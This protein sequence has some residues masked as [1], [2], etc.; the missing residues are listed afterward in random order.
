[1]VCLVFAQ[2]GRSYGKQACR[3]EN[4][5][6]VSST[7]QVPADVSVVGVDR[8]SFV[9]AWSADG[10]T[11]IAKL[12]PAGRLKSKVDRVER[13]GGLVDASEEGTSTTDTEARRKTESVKTFWPS[14]ERGSI[15]AT[16]LEVVSVGGGRVAL[17]MIGRPMHGAPGGA[18]GAIWPSGEGVAPAATRLGPAGEY[19]TRISAAAKGNKL[20]VAW[21][22]GDLSASRLRLARV[23]IDDFCVEKEVVVSRS[24]ILASPV[25]TEANGRV[26]LAWSETVNS[27]TRLSSEVKIAFVSDDLRLVTESTAATGRFIYPTPDIGSVEGGVGVLYRDDDDRDDTPEFY[28]VL[29]N[30]SGKVA[31]HKQRISQSD[32]LRGPSLAS[33]GD[34]NVVATIR[35]F[36]RNLLIGLNRFD[37]A[38]TKLGGEFQ[39]YA[40][41]SDFVRVDLSANEASLLMVYA[42]DR[43]NMGRVIAGQVTCESDR[44]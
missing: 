42:E 27:D 35:S 7:R 20:F 12:D 26:M 8:D 29:L 28:Y 23:R 38:G 31:Q 6:I 19:A 13:T 37:Q 14:L 17:V 43:R 44:Y 9:A 41:K 22:D 32:G 36:Q 2:C 33:L 40:D 30:P 21:H 39:V 15:N 25:L 16:N 1:M 18:Y 3:M 10:A 4:E 34:M 24:E 11:W 5:V